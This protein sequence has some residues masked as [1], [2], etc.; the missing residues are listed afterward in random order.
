ME[1]IG[2]PLITPSMKGW[3]AFPQTLNMDQV[4]PYP[5]VDNPYRYPHYNQY[6]HPGKMRTLYNSP[7]L[8]DSQRM[9]GG[10]QPPPVE[11]PQIAPPIIAPPQNNSRLYQAL[12]ILGGIGLTFML[13][14]TKWTAGLSPQIKDYARWGGALM[15]A[16]GGLWML[17]L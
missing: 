9:F 15:M 5:Y 16:A 3:P 17:I 14:Y 10:Q 1:S 11:K 13:P 6:Q 4:T 7:P 2:N 12:L 8:M